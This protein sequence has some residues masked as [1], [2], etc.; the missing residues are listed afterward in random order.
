[1]D[2]PAAEPTSPAQPRP[3][4]WLRWICGLFLTLILGL[5][6]VWN[7]RLKIVRSVLAR[8]LPNFPAQI[9]SLDWQQGGME[10]R[11][12][13]LTDPSSASPWLEIARAHLSVNPLKLASG[14]LGE[15][16]VETPRVHLTPAI[17]EKLQQP[18]P[19]SSKAPP[20]FHL[21]GLHVNDA[22]LDVLLPS[23]ETATL[24]LNWQAE[25]LPSANPKVWMRS[26]KRSRCGK[27][28]SVQKLPRPEQRPR[29]FLSN[30]L[31]IQPNACLPCINC[32]PPN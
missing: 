22:A 21:S 24:V 2:S 18:Q 20:A 4:R 32:T 10:L 6:L 3:R 12:F 15:I 14:E 1:M 7:F 8:N 19:A 13:K 23:G 5:A 30:A 31:P 26:A 17:L 28:T 27:S 16:T 9:E 11:G 29:K 25:R